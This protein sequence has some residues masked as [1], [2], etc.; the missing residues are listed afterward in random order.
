MDIPILTSDL[1]VRIV[2][3][4]NDV[5]RS[6][7]KCVQR[8]EGNPLGVAEHEFGHVLAT[9]MPKHPERWW[10][11]VGGIAPGDEGQIDD[12]L[13]W[14]RA[15]NLSP[16]IDVVPHQSNDEM[17]KALATHGFR[18]SAFRT[19]LYAVPDSDLPSAAPAIVVREQDDLKLFSNLAAE[20]GFIPEGDE[21]FWKEVARAEFAE[22]RCYIAF[23]DGE[24][25]A[26]A[27]MYIRDRVATFGFGATLEKY[28]G[29][30]CQS[31]L[32][33]ERIA[34]AAKAG[35][36]LAIVQANPGSVSER[37]IV[38]VGMRVA[39]TKAIWSKV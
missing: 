7:I 12:I 23:A 37:N 1:V 15:A 4:E 35:C 34:D 24:P 33:R 21:K 6:R 39:Y 5:T 36:D 30:G 8:I 13:A 25:A 19:V 18:Q 29:R 22:S 3:A 38:R 2:K 28:R 17:L 11:R 10:N 14:Y 16:T 31:A 27:A 32:L 20:T 26:H 9:M